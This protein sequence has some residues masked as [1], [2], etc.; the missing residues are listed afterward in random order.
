G[1]AL[2]LY[3]KTVQI[4][5]SNKEVHKKS[6]LFY[7]LFSSVTI[8]WITIWV[9]TGAIFCHKMWL[10]DLPGSPDTFW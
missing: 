1:A 10:S 5:L 3:F 7:A 4:L 2:L 9:V 6:N 8:F